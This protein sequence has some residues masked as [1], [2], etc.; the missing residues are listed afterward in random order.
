MAALEALRT[1]V[2]TVRAKAKAL[3]DLGEPPD[4]QDCVDAFVL[5]DDVGFE[6]RQAKADVGEAAHHAMP[7]RYATVEGVGDVEKSWGYDRS[8]WDHDSLFNLVLARARDER[9][10]DE[11]TGEYEDPAVVVLRVLR[12]CA[13]IGYWKVGNKDKGTGL[14]GRGIDPD[15]YCTVTDKRPS[16]S[17]PSAAKRAALAARTRE[18]PLEGPESVSGA[19]DGGREPEGV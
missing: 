6:L 7:G 5:L 17:V 18:R 16:V 2:E 13:G 1:V 3:E 10:V 11:E 4:F 14:K 8:G 15:E 12:E 19:P 9:G